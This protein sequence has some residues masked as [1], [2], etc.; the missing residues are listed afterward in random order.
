A[1]C[2]LRLPVHPFPSRAHADLQ[3]ITE[4]ASCLQHPGIP[5]EEKLSAAPYLRPGHAAPRTCWAAEMHAQGT[6][7]SKQLLQKQQSN[8]A[9]ATNVPLPRS[10]RTQDVED[11]SAVTSEHTRAAFV[12]GTSSKTL[13]DVGGGIHPGSGDLETT[14]R[15]GEKVAGSS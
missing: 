9:S 2:S 12:T 6:A 11:E 10:Y 13:E 8:K 7:I 5:L 3:G 14:R 15:S 4:A 1:L